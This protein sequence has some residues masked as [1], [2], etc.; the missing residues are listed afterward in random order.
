MSLKALIAFALLVAVIVCAHPQAK[1]YFT[2]YC[3]YYRY[4]VEK[5]EVITEDGYILTVFRIQQKGSI[6]RQGLKPI[7]LQHGLLDSSDTWIIND[8]DKAPGF[9][10]AN[11]GYDIWLGNSRGNKHSRNHTKYNP[12]KNKQ[13]WDF[14]FQHM[15]D[16]DL[17]ALFTY[18]YKIT[19]QK[20]HYIGHSQGTIQMHIA[21]SK[22]NAVV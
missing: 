1:L 14:T 7:I 2:D 5:H 21:L 8:E 6:I 12:D 13:F 11:R 22:R 15:A 18:V 10:L 20:P 16:Y 19:N 9:M 17:P 4:P 3:K